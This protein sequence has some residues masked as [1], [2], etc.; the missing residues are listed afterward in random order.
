MPATGDRKIRLY[1]RALELDPDFAEAWAA[2]ADAYGERSWQDRDRQAWADSAVHAARQALELD[3]K[4]PDAYVQIGDALV[5]LPDSVDEAVGAYEKAL[6]FQPTHVEA[7]NNLTTVF[8]YRGRLAETLRWLE[9][10]ELASPGVTPGAFRT[11]PV[12][13]Q[14]LVDAILGRDEEAEDRLVRARERHL[15]L[16]EAEFA[17]ALFYD[18]DLGRAREV[19]GRMEARD[20]PRYYLKRRRA[21][22]ALYER[23]WTAARRHYRAL[24]PRFPWG[25]RLFRGFLADDLA[26]AY[27]LHRSGESAEARALAGAA[28]REAETDVS[29]GDWQYPPRLRLSVAHL[30]LA[31]TAAALDWLEDAID[32]GYRDVRMMRTVPVL[33][34]LRH[35]PRFRSL[36]TRI[37]RLL[38]EERRRLGAGD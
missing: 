17:L 12:R 35:H 2:L 8:F 15:S 7:L 6:D 36:A 22:L 28:A 27:A 10:L 33:E 29:G 14:V 21:A 26:L 3:P 1:R 18:Q 9:R 24:Y 5:Y 37:D 13:Q 25:S 11:R 20:E 16:H 38:V 32:S 4:L 30:L 19:L 34:S 23:D 31:D